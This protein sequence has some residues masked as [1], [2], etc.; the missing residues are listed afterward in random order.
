M[1]GHPDNIAILFRA[2]SDAG[3]QGDT[4]RAIHLFEEIVALDPGR[5][6]AWFNLGLLH[7][8]RHDWQAS[9]DANERAYTLRPDHRGTIW[10]LG[11]AATALGD[12]ST[13][14]R[15][16][17][18]Y[19]LDIS[20][21]PGP[22]ESDFGRIPICL[23]PDEDTVVWGHRID[24]ARARIDSIP[25]PSSGYRFHDLILNDGAPIGYRTD[26]DG[27]VAV[28]EA[29]APLHSDGFGCFLLRL[30]APSQSDLA[31]FFQA[32]V[33]PGMG[34]EDWTMDADH[35]TGWQR[36]RTVAVATTSLSEVRAMLTR[37]LPPT[38]ALTSLTTELAPA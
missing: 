36:E 27:E 33:W 17:H 28:L 26:H 9:F 4:A 19:G 13:A 25:P 37:A 23:H 14:R 15:M 32:A 7:K 6:S 5:A 3:H 38:I 8:R 16:W 18:A 30:D 24:P 29:L 1:S 21:G 20:D 2:A 12:W 34:L 10:N 22:I 11:I 31:A 35:T